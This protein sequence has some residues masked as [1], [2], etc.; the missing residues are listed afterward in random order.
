MCLRYV[1]PRVAVWLF[2]RQMRKQ[3]R[4]AFGQDFDSFG[5]GGRPQGRQ[6]QK[7]SDDFFSAFRGKSRKRGNGGRRGKLIGKDVGEYVDFE[8]LPG[9]P[10]PRFSPST[11]APQPQIV[12]VEWE[13]L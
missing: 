11:F 9:A 5:F 4:Q 10:A 7:G 6:E 1:F 12:D 2:R 3:A 13:D 8:E